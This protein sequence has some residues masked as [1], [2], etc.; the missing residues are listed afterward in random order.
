MLRHP[1]IAKFTQQLSPGANQGLVAADTFSIGTNVHLISGSCHRS[2]DPPFADRFSGDPQ[3]L[4]GSP[5]RLDSMASP[6]RAGNITIKPAEVRGRERLL[7]CRAR[8]N[9]RP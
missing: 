7:L 5:H 1:W 8:Q 2:R 3:V 9:C 4:C 6:T